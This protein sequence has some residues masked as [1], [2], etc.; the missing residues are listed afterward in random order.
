MAN[1]IESIYAKVAFFAALAFLK[2]ERRTQNLF[3]DEQPCEERPFG[4]VDRDDYFGDS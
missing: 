2:Q 4:L 1:A 3:S